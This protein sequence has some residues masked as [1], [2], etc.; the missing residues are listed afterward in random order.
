[1]QSRISNLFLCLLWLGFAIRHLNHYLEYRSLTTLLFIA[2]ETLAALMFLFRSQTKSYSRISFD[3]VVAISAQVLPFLFAP[4][5]LGLSYQLGSALMISGAILNILALLSLNRSLAIV[6][7]ERSIK[8][9]GLYRLIRHPMYLSYLILYSGYLLAS[10]SAWNAA[11]FLLTITLLFMR[12]VFEE[13]FLG[14]VGEYQD[15]R[16]NVKYRLIPL[17]Y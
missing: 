14:A 4:S 16:S 6:P 5:A 2:M 10:T 12:T 13:R 1:M 17:I 3:W 9:S 8:T 7:A 11:I 15:Y